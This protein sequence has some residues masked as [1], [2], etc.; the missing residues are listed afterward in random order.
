MGKNSVILVAIADDHP[1]VR[2][3]IRT[4]LEN[5][6][7]IKIDAEY[8]AAAPLMRDFSNAAWEVLILDVDLKDH[9]GVELTKQMLLVR[10]ELKILILSISP[11]KK[12]AMRAMKAGAKGYVNKNSVLDSLEE[13]VLQVASGQLYVSKQLSQLLAE[14]ALFK[15]KNEDSHAMLSD[16][17]LQV[18]CLYGAGRSNQEIAEQLYISI[19]TVSTY[20]RRILDKMNLRTTADLI[21][22]AI[23]H[24]LVT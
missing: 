13:A 3:G 6:P 14:Q 16:R 17:E 8:S 24:E 4:L 7:R 20:R 22:Y 1:V 10:P 15:N 2:L 5:T 12:Y 23:F 11:E 19:K 18:L 21:S 9:N